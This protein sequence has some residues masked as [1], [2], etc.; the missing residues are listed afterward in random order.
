MSRHVQIGDYAVI[1]IHNQK[2]YLVITDIK[3]SHIIAGEHIIIPMGNRW[4]VQD[5][6]MEHTVR[7]L[8]GSSLPTYPEITSQIL[9]SLPYKDLISACLTNKDFNKV[10]QDEYFWKLKVERDYGMLTQYKPTDITYS[11]QYIDL[12]DAKD[13]HPKPISD[14]ARKD[15]LELSRLLAQ[16]GFNGMMVVNLD[17]QNANEAARN[18]RLDILQWLSQHNIYPDRAG[19]HYAAVRG[20]LEVLKWLAQMGKFSPT[21]KTANDAASYGQLEVLKLLAQH[22]T[23][24]NEDGAN[25]A[26]HNSYLEILQWMAKARNL[27][28]NQIGIDNAA[29]RGHLKVLQWLAQT[30]NA[31][32]NQNVYPSQEGV[33]FVA[34]FGHLEVLKW[35]AQQNIY[36]DQNGANN[37]AKNGYLEILK[38]LAQIPPNGIYPDGDGANF[39][40][41]YGHLE[42]LKWLAQQRNIYPDEDGAK[43][44]KAGRHSNVVKWLAQNGIYPR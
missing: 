7:F 15:Q 39:A 10:C 11:Q 18:G 41:E 22:N 44:A 5:Y 9:L 40:A 36:P 6:P 21:Q 20:H 34:F 12:L 1:T 30:K 25:K 2:Y 13:P 31:R 3:P 27:Y 26:A 43:F 28:P 23:Y 33:N 19:T 32:P 14:A 17:Q 37:A 4:M 16:G 29:A 24:P 42:V 8:M 38:W 35:L